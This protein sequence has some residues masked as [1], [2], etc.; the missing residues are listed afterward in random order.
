M[1]TLDMKGYKVLPIS[2]R[3]V[4]IT[5]G[6]LFERRQLNREVTIPIEFEQFEKTGRFEAYEMKWKPGDY[7]T[8]HQH[9]DSELG[10]LIEAVGYSLSA[11]PNPEWESIIDDI[12]DKIEKAALQDGYFNVYYRQVEPD[13]RFTN[14]FF[15]HE[16]YSAGHMI[17]GA[18]A[19]YEATGKRKLL[20]IMIRYAD[21]LCNTFGKE[22]GKRRGFDGHAEIELALVKLYRITG[23][24][25]Y[26][27]LCGYFIDDR[28]THPQFFE[29]EKNQREASGDIKPKDGLARHRVDFLQSRGPY[30]VYQSHKPLREQDEP[31]GHAVRATYLYAGMSDFAAITDDSELM[32]ACKRIWNAT[33]LKY[34]SITGGVGS[35]PNGERFSFEYDIPNEST[36]NETCAALGFAM[37]T[38]RMLCV[39]GEARYADVLEQVIYNIILSGVS[40][41]GDRFFY[42]N[43]LS[44]Y[45]PHFEHADC[46]MSDSMRSERQEWFGVACC[47]PNLAR[48]MASLGG[49][50]Y[51]QDN[52]NIYVNLYIASDVLFK[53]GNAS[54]RLAVQTDYPW[55]GEVLITVCTEASV[56][57]TLLLRVPAWSKVES[58]ELNGNVIEAPVNNGYPALSK[59]W[60]N[61]DNIRLVLDIPIRYMKSHPSVRYNAGRVA[62]MRGPLVYCFE[63]IDNGKDLA[64]MAI[65]T[66]APVVE[67]ISDGFFGQAVMLSMPGVKPLHDGWEDALYRETELQADD[68]IFKAI[69]YY[70]WQNRGKGEMITWVLSKI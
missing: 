60:E 46:T 65:Y 58:L 3:D 49:Y 47:P 40:L 70:L 35:T 57:A 23:N 7:Y 37:W 42:A 6:L 52:D 27:D 24:R 11:E 34:M 13:K 31:A 28:G 36:F 51:G 54:L 14:L 48:F 62:L 43:Y 50:A 38:H 41:S 2:W 59:L 10:K 53:V 68:M 5:G 22:P 4:H 8:P 16:L 32:A 18:I 39:T 19:Y 55:N 44:V 20:D 64:G 1:R 67:T 17:E 61:G 45:P 66:A 63:E 30:A 33:A 56:N 21:L 26:I 29:I 15:M 69:P 9:W 25:S 12:A